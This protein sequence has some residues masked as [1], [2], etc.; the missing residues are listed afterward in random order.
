MAVRAKVAWGAAKRLDRLL[1]LLYQAAAAPEQWPWFLALLRNLT[2]AEKAALPH[3]E[4]VKTLEGE[5]SRTARYLQPEAVEKYARYYRI[6]DE[7]VNGYRKFF[8]K[9]GV[10]TSEQLADFQAL[11]VPRSIQIT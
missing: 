10:A 11:S 5:R 8:T 9:G 6:Q 4:F 3:H 2:N 1:E 7:Y